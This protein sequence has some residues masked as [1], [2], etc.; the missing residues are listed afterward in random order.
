MVCLGRLEPV[1]FRDTDQGLTVVG[2]FQMVDFTC[3]GQFTVR[4]IR[5]DVLPR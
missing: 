2:E 1:R 3:A 5:D 4:R